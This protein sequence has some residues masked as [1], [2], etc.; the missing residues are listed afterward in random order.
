MNKFLTALIAGA[1]AFAAGSSMAQNTAVPSD[2]TPSTYTPAEQAKSK[3][4]AAAKKADTAS[5]T[6]DQKAAARKARNA[7][8]QAQLNTLEKKGDTEAATKGT[9]VNKAAAQSKAGPAP[10]KGTLNNPTT[11]KAMQ[12]D[13]A[14]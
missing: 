12:K 10:A 11:A 1:F 3:S 6:K 7:N 14:Q 2:K 13:K 8:K 9:D 5:M 4:E